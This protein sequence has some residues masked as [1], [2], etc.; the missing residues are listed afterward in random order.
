L[1]FS[2][3][4]SSALSRTSMIR[5]KYFLNN[6]VYKEK[7]L[8]RE[9]QIANLINQVHLTTHLQKL[10]LILTISGHIYLMEKPQ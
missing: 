3:I 7:R 9:P 5:L 4:E 10:I 6:I 8:R 1:C 2:P